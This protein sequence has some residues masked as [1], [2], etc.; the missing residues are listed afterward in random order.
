VNSFFHFGNKKRT[1]LP[2][3]Y[4]ERPSLRMK[5]VLKVYFAKYLETDHSS[6]L[7]NSFTPNGHAKGLIDSS[8]VITTF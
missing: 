1:N 6:E 4:Q 7:T 3:Q 5:N 2:F 8:Y